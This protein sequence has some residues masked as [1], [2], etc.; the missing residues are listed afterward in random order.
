MKKDI[1]LDSP[2]P[3][4]G[5]GFEG[6][7]AAAGGAGGGVKTAG[8][9]GG[10][11]GARDPEDEELPVLPGTMFFARA[12]KMPVRISKAFQTES[13]PTPPIV[14]CSSVSDIMRAVSASWQAA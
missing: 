12:S 9:A 4:A 3:C 14:R 6:G 5:G 2:E 1:G 13:M 10:G 8:A 7:G 11:A